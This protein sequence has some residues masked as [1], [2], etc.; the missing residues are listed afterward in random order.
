MNRRSFL[1]G[2][3]AG[4]V[5][6]RLPKPVLSP[7]IGELSY[8][9]AAQMLFMGDVVTLSAG[10]VSKADGPQEYVMGMFVRKVDHL[11]EI[12]LTDGRTVL[13]KGEPE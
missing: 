9:R 12:M 11:C 10:Y 1:L 2:V 4:A 13:M 5:A 3:A 7:V 6:A 8:P